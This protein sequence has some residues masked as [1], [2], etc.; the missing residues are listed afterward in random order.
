M[1]LHRVC[2][3]GE[4]RSTSG[5]YATAPASAGDV[6]AA[7]AKPTADAC[8]VASTSGSRVPVVTPS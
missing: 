2:G 4:L 5:V 7:T 6:Y 8:G 3:H 1:M